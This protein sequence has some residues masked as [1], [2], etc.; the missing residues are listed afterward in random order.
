MK[1]LKLRKSD[2]LNNAWHSLINQWVLHQQR[3]PEMLKVIIH[4][5]RVTRKVRGAIQSRSFLGFTFFLG[6]FICD[7]YIFLP[8]NGPSLRTPLVLFNSLFSLLGMIYFTTVA[9]PSSIN[10]QFL[11]IFVCSRGMVVNLSFIVI[12]APPLRNSQV[13]YIKKFSRFFLSRHCS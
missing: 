1:M 13:A 3:R 5:I 8:F 12:M 4:P 10:H 2:N 7:L 6:L 11:L 9:L